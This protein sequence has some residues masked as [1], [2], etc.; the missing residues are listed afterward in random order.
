MLTVRHLYKTIDRQ[1]VLRDV[2]FTL[3]PGM[4]AGLVGRNGAGKT[5]LLKT[6]AGIYDPDRGNVLLDGESIHRRPALK[7]E[8]VFLPDVPEALYGY[9]AEECARLYALV[10]PRFDR[11]LFDS[12][13]RR[14]EL[15]SGR[16]VRHFSRGMKM[17]LSASLGIATRA[18][19]VLLDEPTNGIDPIAKKQ[20]LSL[21]AEA[22]SEG[23]AML[24]SS[25]LLNELERLSDR[26]LLIGDGTVET[27]ETEDPSRGRLVKL[28]VVFAGEPPAAWL[29]SPQV[30]VLDH[31]GRVHTLIVSRED[32]DA[33]L[34]E[35]RR[36]QPVVLEE[37]PLK[38]E[39]LFFWKLG[40]RSD[41]R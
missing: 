36:M 27:H 18:R 21:L 4:V 26:I 28:Q 15:P 40:G 39:D 35:L 3:E 37:L 31:V 2:S 20:L 17:L 6:M 8:I 38:L 11:E 34:E 10:Y 9:S 5:T 30:K 22:A 7:R 25:H 1:P 41:E 16:N 29:A 32:G 19:Y 14:F 33:A 23:M 24:I 13:L 12:L